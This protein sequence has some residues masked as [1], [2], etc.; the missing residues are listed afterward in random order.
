MRRVEFRLRPLRPAATKRHVG[1]L[2]VVFAVLSVP[3][4][5]Q[6]VGDS[7]TDAF[8]QTLTFN[9]A[10]VTTIQR[11]A[12]STQVLGRLNGGTVFD[13]TFAAAVA[14]PS[15]QAGFSLAR[16]AITT[17]G[18]PGVI[19]GAPHLLSSNTTSSTSSSSLF[20]LAGSSST[21][22]TEVLF[23]PGTVTTGAVSTCTV[24]NT[25][26]ATRPTCTTGG[27]T[28]RAV[29]DDETNF[30]TIHTTNS[31]INTATTNTTTTTLAEVW[32]L[33]GTVQSVGT[34]HTSAIS[35]VF[36]LATR[37]LRRL[38]DESGFD[39]TGS[40]SN[41]FGPPMAFAA[42]G[43]ARRNDLPPELLAY[44]KAPVYKAPAPAPFAPRYGGWAEGYGLWSR[45]SSQG[46]VPGDSRRA[47]GVAGGFTY[48][49]TPNLMFGFGVDQGWQHIDLDAVS[50]S[51]RTDLTQFG[52]SGAFRS[53]N[54]IAN[55]SASYGF[56]DVGTSRNLPGLAASASYDTTLVGVLGEVGYRLRFG[57]LRLTPK[58]GV[59]FISVR[60]DAFT[61]L[62]ALALAAQSHT[63]DRTRVYAGLEAAQRFAVT[64][65]S[66]LDLSGYGRVVDVVSG[67]D[68]LLP[69][70]FAVAPGAPLVV[71]GLSEGDVGFD[72]GAKAALALT[73]NALVY[74]AYD[75]RFRD[76]FEAHAASRCGGSL[77]QATA[78][79]AANLPARW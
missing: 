14:D 66:K 15:V 32:A 27:G 61:E 18:G 8:V 13:Q 9:P 44:A 40:V 70:A 43:E 72:A 25:P 35:G 29:G 33:D 64:P 5:A 30:N 46:A 19:I 12:F 65:V 55:A 28:P 78:R 53:G 17:A 16:L 21:V 54:F 38:D 45:A 60:T 73:P 52:V 58:A 36:D 69:V 75:G 71:Q 47:A 59:D 37:F 48:Q 62:G 26:T 51:A 10:I 79:Q 20:S 57:D 39:D 11:N 24:P 22:R 41:G 50:E 23:G 1:T 3:A 76:G 67:A 68:V 49:A 7:F 4:K 31:T 77:Q 42:D 56:G 74:A 6:V 2:A 34:A 63:T